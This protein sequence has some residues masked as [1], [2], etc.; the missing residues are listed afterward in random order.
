MDSDQN[1]YIGQFW[2]LLR[3]CGILCY[4]KFMDIFGFHINQITKP[5]VIVQRK[6]KENGWTNYKF[7]ERYK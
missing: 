2:N 7:K 5:V 4:A 6:G 1:G 3:I